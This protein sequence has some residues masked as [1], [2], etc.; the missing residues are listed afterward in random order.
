MQWHVMFAIDY[1]V[2]HECWYI[3]SRDDAT[4]R[5]RRTFKEHRGNPEHTLVTAHF[6]SSDEAIA[7]AITSLGYGGIIRQG[8]LR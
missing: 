7:H 8:V 3:E 5:V 2:A 6:H 1:P 4:Y